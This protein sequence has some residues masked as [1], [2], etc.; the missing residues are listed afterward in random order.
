MPQYRNIAGRRYLKTVTGLTKSGAQKK[1]RE[2]RVVLGL[3]VRIVSDG[4]GYYDVYT[5]G[6]K[7][8]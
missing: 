6:R 7:E 3:M 2:Y 8:R 4:R 1:A 5:R